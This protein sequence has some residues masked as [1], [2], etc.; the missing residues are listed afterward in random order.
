MKKNHYLKKW[1]ITSLLFLYAGLMFGQQ[2]E[3]TGTVTEVSTGVPVPG[4]SVVEEN[5][6]NGTIT[7]LDGRYTL[8]VTEGATVVFSF[9]GFA[10]QELVPDASGTYNIQ[11]EPAVFDVDEV[12]VTALG[13]SREKKSLGYTVS[14]VKSEEV[15]RVKETNVMNSLAGRVAGVTITQGGFGPGG[16]SRVV[17]R[18]NNSLSQ[19]NQPLYVVDG[20]PI[21][22]SGYGSANA[23][24]VG[25]YSKTDYGTGVSDINPDDI[26]S[27]SVLKGPNAAALYGSR[28]A[29][30]V[31]LITTKKGQ[32]RKG[33]GVTVSSSITFEEPMI[34]PDYQNQYGQG[35][36]GYVAD[37]IEDLKEAGASWGAKL[38]GSDKLYWTG[39][40]RPYTAQ[41]D[42]VKNFF[43][44]GQTLITNVALDGGNQDANVR[45]SYTNT[46]A[47]SI[48]PNSG[49]DRHNFTLRGYVKL[50]DRL[51]LDAKAT[52]FYQ[53]GENRPKLGTEGVMSY[54]Y[55]IPR[56]ANINDY[57]D[58]QDPATLE[59]VSHSSLGANP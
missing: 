30:G 13:I 58:Y 38:D 21:D 18:G 28:A 11:M 40:T 39:E 3:I 19:D 20:V 53:H 27:I 32:N 51:T 24:D 17:I 37:N 25:A 9:V 2:V 56:N 46:H 7:D 49:I 31:I 48:L 34:L 36:Q 16:S 54:V 59:A 26:E 23:N 52:Y 42:N 55:G 14:E 22:N 12:V 5:T 50:A 6:A 57:K 47:N 15:S 35:T 44:T 43:E 45:F 29:N 10:K 8:N 1:I 4:V 41:P 33:L